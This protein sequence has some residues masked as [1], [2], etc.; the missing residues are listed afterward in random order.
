MENKNNR[1]KLDKVTFASDGKLFKT[2]CI[3]L[4]FLAFALTSAPHPSSKL[5]L[6]TT[7][8]QNL[9]HISPVGAPFHD[10][11]P[12]AL[13]ADG[14]AASRKTT[15]PQSGGGGST[16]AKKSYSQ[17]AKRSTARGRTPPSSDDEDEDGQD[18]E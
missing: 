3:V 18:S 2:I 9:S 1:E 5:Q 15:R 14:T 7:V 10:V 13:P 4:A 17:A 12:D 11:P 6:R 8:M 16:D